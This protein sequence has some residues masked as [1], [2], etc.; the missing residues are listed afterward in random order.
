MQK[1]L[2]DFSD[3]WVA[4]EAFSEVDALLKSL[5]TEGRSKAPLSNR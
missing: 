4:I 5:R 3:E 1:M 2:P